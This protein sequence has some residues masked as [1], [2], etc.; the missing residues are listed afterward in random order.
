MLKNKYS[1]IPKPIRY[2]TGEGFF[3][4]SGSVLIYSYPEYINQEKILQQFILKDTNLSL[5]VTGH[6]KQ[7]KII[8]LLFNKNIIH[9]EAY[10]LEIYADNVTISASASMGIFYGIQTLRQ[11]V[12]QCP[13][14]KL[15]AAVIEDY[16]RFEWR[17]LHLDVSRHFFPV[18]FIYKFLDVMAFYKFNRFH[19]HLTDDQGWRIEI[20]KYPELTK[21]GSFRK[22]KDG[23]VYGG[24][25]SQEE[26]RQVV[27]YAEKLHIKI[28]PEIEM[29]GHAVAVIAVYPELSCRQKKLEVWNR[30]GISED[31]FCA[32]K[33][34]TFT[35][36]ENVL[37][38][39]IDL[40]PGEYIHIGG[41]E[42]PKKRW[43]KCP[44]CQKRMAEEGLKNEEELQSYF[45]RRISSYLVK[46][47]KKI[48]GWDEI[49]DGGFTEKAV[50]MA[51]REDGVRATNKDAD[52]GD[53]VICCPNKVCYFDWKQTTTDKRGVFGVSTIGNIYNYNPI[54][55]NLSEEKAG[56]IIGVQ[57]NIW[58][59]RMKSAEI[60]EYMT[61]PR[62]LAVAETGWSQNKYN[63]EDFTERVK[64]HL[65][66]L[67]VMGINSCKI[68]ER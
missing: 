25:Y 51:W 66:I 37:S 43:K 21:T 54:P 36:L 8:R 68:I 32:G 60:V 17:G 11:I 38:E 31:V 23:S 2:E 53:D 63:W 12:L 7:N 1:I 46:K 16:P 58:T 34:Q 33:E 29:P 28:L 64:V 20:K 62:A 52:I 4:L 48:I 55:K 42:C 9:P 45:M 27:T 56:H 67:S 35:F 26:I 19:W 6:N 59:E 50:I 3:Y 5:K 10:I 44:D 39:V 15:A 41:D 57:G 47:G 30:W 13:D 65:E 14:M 40:F 18:S 24:Y 22:Q 61:F 49:L